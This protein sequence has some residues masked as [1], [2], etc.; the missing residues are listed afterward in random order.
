MLA[1][2]FAR[3]FCNTNWLPQANIAPPKITAN[4]LLESSYRRLSNL[5]VGSSLWSCLIDK[6]RQTGETLS[7]GATWSGR[8]IFR[9]RILKYNTRCLFEQADSRTPI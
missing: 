1:Q 5:L 2:R 4:G 6:Y 8:P 3:V 9:T 7:V